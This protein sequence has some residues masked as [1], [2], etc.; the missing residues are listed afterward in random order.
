MAMMRFISRGMPT[1]LTSGGSQIRDT[2]QV[3]ASGR[4]SSLYRLARWAWSRLD[5]GADCSVCSYPM[6]V[7]LSRILHGTGF[8]RDAGRT[9]TRT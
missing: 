3:E 2:S 7:S 8:T 5:G 9:G 6:R 1:L 4:R